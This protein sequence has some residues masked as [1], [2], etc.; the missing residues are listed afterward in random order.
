M[1]YDDENKLYIGQREVTK[2][3]YD[4]EF[5]HKTDRR[6]QL[7]EYNRQHREKKNYQASLWYDKH[8]YNIICEC[9]C[10]VK[11]NTLS[12]HKKS[13][14]HKELVEAKNLAD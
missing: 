8:N 4:K 7:R 2:E 14:K 10:E 11:R 6:K 5:R 1:R 13:R 9:G 12:S 3:E